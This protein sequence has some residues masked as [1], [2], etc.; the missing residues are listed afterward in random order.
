[1]KLYF[2]IVIF[3]NRTS[4]IALHYTNH[5]SDSVTERIALYTLLQVSVCTLRS[6]IVK[7]A[8]ILSK[9]FYD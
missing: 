8:K 1:M 6:G 2:K 7:T 9:F 4:Q 5:R 3:T